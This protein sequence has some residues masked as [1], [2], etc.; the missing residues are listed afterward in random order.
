MKTYGRRR[1]LEST[2]RSKWKMKANKENARQ[3]LEDDLILEKLRDEEWFYFIHH[4]YQNIITPG[5]LPESPNDC[6]VGSDYLENRRF[7]LG[8]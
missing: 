8:F 5:T 6:F 4:D 3:S 7:E 1:S 2:I